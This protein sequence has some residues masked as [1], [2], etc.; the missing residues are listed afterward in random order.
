MSYPQNPVEPTAP[1]VPPAPQPTESAPKQRNVLGI[2]ALAI[3]VVGFLFACIPG[4]LIVGWIL[5]PIAFILSIV[6]FFLKGRKWPAITALIVSVVGTIVGFIV[7]FAVVAVSFNDAFGSGDT[8]VVESSDDAV[9]DEETT[10]EEPATA[11]EGT[12]ENPFPLGTT[13]SS[14]EWEVTI[15]S[16][17]LGATDQVIAANPAWNEA[18]DD[19]TEYIVVNY[20][21]TY[22]GDDAE[23]QM[24]AFVGVEYVTGSGTTVNSLDKLLIAP[25]PTVDSTSPLYNGGS[26]TGNSAIQVPTPVDG[27]LAVRPGMLADKVF[28]AV[29]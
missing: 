27:V 19:G 17:T 8:T 12:R 3:A 15:N 29:Q 4:A 18:P 9:V 25:E 26:V 6:A 16:V 13:V 14:D 10:E 2:V 20:S 11:E 28:F 23:G 1:A 24:A 21:A 5:L 7:F 22:I